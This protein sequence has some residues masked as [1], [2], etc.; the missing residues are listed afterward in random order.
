MTMTYVGS[1][2]T[3]EG[4]AT[5]QVLDESTV[6]A[7]LEMG[8][9]IDVMRQAMIDFSAGLVEQPVRQMVPTES[10]FL[11]V[12]AA[13]GGSLDVKLVTLYPENARL[14]LD[15]HQAVIVMFDPST[16]EPIA[17]MDGRLVTE[18]RTA[19]VSA[20]AADLFAK[21]ESSVLGV[22]GSGVQARSHIDAMRLIRDFEE[23]RIWSRAPEHAESLAARIGA[24]A[25][26]VR[27]AVE[28]ADVVVA[29]TSATEP[30]FDGSWLRSGTHVCS[31]GAPRP[32]WRELD[33]QTMSNV[34]I[35]DSRTAAAV[36]S[37]DII[38]SGATIDAELGEVLS[39]GTNQF[40][41]RTTVFKS[42][43]LAIEDIRTAQLV[44]DAIA[45]P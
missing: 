38:G 14:G 11:G 10:G 39:S 34:M 45:A 4:V 23:V 12:M 22:L 7:H 43:G 35:V 18:M 40:E 30:I 31:V 17:V 42:L 41:G 27:A 6:A 36:E 13:Y 15:S 44:L 24:T 28:G 8:P 32:D 25:T 26:S 20:V 16:G 9:L 33:D 29:A 5:M 21:S 19:A 37:G 1:M 2:T 3:P